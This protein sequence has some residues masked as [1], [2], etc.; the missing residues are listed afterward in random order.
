MPGWLI[1][2]LIV[3]AVVIIIAVVLYFVGKRLEK[4]QNESQAMLEANKQSVSMLIID[5]K[6]MKLKDAQLP[7]NVMDQVPKYSRGMKVPLCKVK[8]GPQ[9]LT[10]FCDEKIYDLIPVKKEVKAEVSG[11]YIVNVKGVHGTVIKKDEKKKSAF[12]RALDKAK[13]KAGA[14]QI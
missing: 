10:M 8:I 2:L 5:K 12:R 13:E 1:T 7:Q 3:L 11:M 14:K 9:I 6:R 4:K